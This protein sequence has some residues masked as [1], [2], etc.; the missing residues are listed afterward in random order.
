MF[1]KGRRN[2]SLGVISTIKDMSDTHQSGTMSANTRM[3]CIITLQ[4]FYGVFFI[5]GILQ[6]ALVFYK[7][8][9]KKK[10]RKMTTNELL[11]LHLTVVDMLILMTLTPAIFYAEADVTRTSFLA[12]RVMYPMVIFYPFT[13]VFTQVVIALERRR[14]I[15]T[16]LRLRF[17]TFSIASMLSLCWLLSAVLTAPVIWDARMSPHPCGNEEPES[18]NSVIYYTLKIFLQFIIPLLII[19]VCY[20]QAGLALRRS[21]YRIHKASEMKSIALQQEASRLKNVRVCKAFAIMVIMFTVCIAPLNVVCLWTTYG[22]GK[23]EAVE[24]QVLFCFL[25]NFP[26]L[27]MSFLDPIIYGT[28]CLRLYGRS[29]IKDAWNELVSWTNKAISQITCSCK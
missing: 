29:Q 26:V 13:R 19:T 12:C 22:S 27:F 8:K 15:V 25:A 17:T 21:Q 3:R 11:M 5:I 23:Y 10:Y 24:N 16:P 18:H 6:N 14:A 28:C 9:K 7:I 1:S 2:S 4:V 20:V